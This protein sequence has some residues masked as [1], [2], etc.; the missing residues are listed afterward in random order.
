LRVIV[1]EGVGKGAFVIMEK[2][3]E[4]GSDGYARLKV[5]SAHELAAAD[6]VL[7]TY[8]TLRTDLSHDPSKTQTNDRSL[9]YIK[10]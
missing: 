9:R 10:R 7:T 1:Y 4:V 5:V 3:K 8:D 6:I 2:G